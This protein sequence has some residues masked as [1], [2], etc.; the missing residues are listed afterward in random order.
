MRADFEEAIWEA[1]RF[2]CKFST[3]SG[4]KQQWCNIVEEHL[5]N[6]IAALHSPTRSS[7]SVQ[8]INDECQLLMRLLR[9][10]EPGLG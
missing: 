7:F 6:A 5:A 1:R 9:D 4:E 2:L 3:S 10:D 8:A